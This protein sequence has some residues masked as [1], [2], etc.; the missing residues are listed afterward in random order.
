MAE[1]ARE[2]RMVVVA[3]DDSSSSMNAFEWAV[4]NLLKPEDHLRLIH[5]QPFHEVT[6][7]IASAEMA[8]PIY[9]AG[10]VREDSLEIAK[11]FAKIC[12]ELGIKDFKED[13]ILEDGS[14][15]AAICEYI[16]ALPQKKAED[17]VLVLG[18]RELGFF[19]RAFLGSVSEHC[20]RHAHCPV[21]VIKL[22][23]GKNKA[24]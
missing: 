22:P 20:V 9:S 24:E 18:S 14:A 4:K 19:K 12:R 10:K 16:E 7:V 13:I 21:V 17:V 6:D 3:I 5:V 1:A 23:G 11:K 8:V 2:G 15:G